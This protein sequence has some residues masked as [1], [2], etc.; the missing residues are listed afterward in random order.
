[1]C[2]VDAKTAAAELGLTALVL[3]GMAM[4][5]EVPATKAGKAWLFDVEA[6]RGCL[7]ER[8]RA[9]VSEAPQKVRRAPNPPKRNYARL[10]AGAD[11]VAEMRAF[12]G[13]KG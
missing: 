1:M 7:R 11:A 4:R 8:M 5:R 9:H 10:G 3:R 13:M 2:F 12:L 6:V